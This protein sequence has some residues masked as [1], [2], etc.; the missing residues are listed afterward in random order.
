M[1]SSSTC[2][3]S[4]ARDGHTWNPRHPRFT[5]HTTC[6]RSATTSASERVPFGVDTIEVSSQSGRE[7]GTRFWK[8]L[9]PST[10]SG[11]RCISTGRPPIARITGS[12]TVR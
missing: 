12:P 8:K 5:A 11:K 7:A 6:A 2:S 9:L 1:R 4:A 3:G 10:P